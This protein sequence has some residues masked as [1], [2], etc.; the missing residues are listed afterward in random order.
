MERQLRNFWVLATV[1][2]LINPAFAKSDWEDW[3]K[4]ISKTS[5]QLVLTSTREEVPY[6]KMTPKLVSFKGSIK[7]PSYMKLASGSPKMHG[8]A[9][10]LIIDGQIVC[11]Y[12]PRSNSDRYY[13]LRE[14]SNGSRSGEQVEVRNKLEV[15]LN[16]ASSENAAL[17]ATVTVVRRDSIDYGIIFPYVQADEGQI[18]MYNGE[19]WVAADVSELDL[20]GV[21]GEKGDKGDKGEP[22]IAG[23]QGPAG[24]DGA[25]GVAG[26][27]GDKGDKGDAGAQGSAGANGAVGATGAIG[28]QGPAGSNG[29]VGATGA[30]GPQG[31]AGANGAVGATG[32]IGPQGPAGLNGAVGSTGAIGPQGPVGVAGVDGAPGVAG[33]QGPAG[34][35][36]VAGAKGDKGDKGDR[37]LSEIAYLRDERASGQQ[38]GGCVVNNWNQRSLNVLGGDTGF[39]SLA[40]NRFVL[41]PGKYFIEVSAPA[42]ATASHQAKLKVIETNADVII[43]SNGFSHPSSQSLTQSVIQGEIIVTSA[44]TFEIQH[45]CQIDKPVNG[46]GYATN[47]GTLEIYTQVKILKKE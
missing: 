13:V 35:A 22:G 2:T 38:G 17:T 46:F 7:I 20:A 29:A 5:K 40:N 18:L 19:A 9:G 4:R 11:D 34:T 44:S 32:A 16:Y 8:S 25:Q 23:P 27:K 36:G 10:Q 14:C 21:A 47:F 3:F 28:P 42:Y 39:I 30:I 37:G 26:A 43:G 33:P 45:R 31:P 12:S 24:N 41:Q 1:L 15:K 6:Y